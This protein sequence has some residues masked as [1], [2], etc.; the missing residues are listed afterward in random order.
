MLEALGDDDDDDD[1]IE[2]TEKEKDAAR[3]N[4]EIVG[5]SKKTQAARTTA[6]SREAAGE[7]LRRM[8][9]GGR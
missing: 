4:L 1:E 3:Q 5:V 2:V 7:A 6:T 9:S 8:F